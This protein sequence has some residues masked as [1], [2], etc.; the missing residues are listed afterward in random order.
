MNSIFDIY[1]NKKDK[2]ENII[3]L[4]GILNWIENLPISNL[5]YVEMGFDALDS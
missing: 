3:K 1:P 4:R 5:S 2:T